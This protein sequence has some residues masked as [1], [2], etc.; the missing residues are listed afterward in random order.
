MSI[1]DILTTIRKGMIVHVP[2]RYKLKYFHDMHKSGL[3]M[4]I[5]S[6]SLHKRFEPKKMKMLHLIT[7]KQKRSIHKSLFLT[8]R[9]FKKILMLRSNTVGPLLKKTWT[10][11]RTLWR[12][13]VWSLSRLFQAFCILRL[14]CCQ[15]LTYYDSS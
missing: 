1:W 7:R 14:E 11:E 4:I 10:F 8:C 2:I 9:Q 13:G 5:L 3:D 6:R 15:L 12:L